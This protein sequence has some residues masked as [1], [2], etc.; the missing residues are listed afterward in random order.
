MEDAEALRRL[1]LARVARLATVDGEGAPHLVPLVFALDHRP[2]VSAVDHKPKRTTSLQRIRNI[3][4]NPSVS[5]LADQYDEDWTRLWWV[6]V[7]GQATVLSD[8]EETA[9]VARLLAAKYGQCRER[10]P[11]G[12]AIIIQIESVNGWSAEP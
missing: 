8:E 2:I 7:D 1:S 3:N 6:R 5:V 11:I 10:P 4:L 12:P 9:G